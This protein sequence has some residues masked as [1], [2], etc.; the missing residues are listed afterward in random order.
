MFGSGL[1]KAAYKKEWTFGV[2]FLEKTV[3][4]KGYKNSTAEK[5]VKDIKKNKKKYIQSLKFKVLK[6]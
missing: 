2:Q 1:D 3:T 4:I 6:K 5:F